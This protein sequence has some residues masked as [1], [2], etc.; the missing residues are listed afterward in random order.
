MKKQKTTPPANSIEG[1]LSQLP[2]AELEKLKK[3]LIPAM[4]Y[5]KILVDDIVDWHVWRI[6]EQLKKNAHL[7][8]TVSM[9]ITSARALKARWEAYAE[10]HN[11]P[12]DKIAFDLENR[13]LFI[14]VTAKPGI[15]QILEN[16]HTENSK[17]KKRCP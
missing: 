12:A 4:Q 2:K 9:H 1:I 14:E 7:P 3:R 8:A 11:E 6:S 16:L 5:Q 13:S 15:Q 10:K 17:Y